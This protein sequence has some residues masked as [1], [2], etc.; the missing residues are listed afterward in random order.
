M[1]ESSTVVDHDYEQ[2][3]GR[4]GEAGTRVVWLRLLWEERR[5]LRNFT[6]CGMG[7]AI[8]V[9]LLLPVSY[10]SRTRLMPPDQQSSSG[11][12]MIAAVAG[13]GSGGDGI[14]G[15]LGSSLGGM[16]GNLLGIKST[17]ALIADML[18][19]PTIQDSLIEK[20]N[21]RKA[22]GA[23]YWEDARRVLASN[24]TIR[25]DKKSGVLTIAVQDRDRNRAQAMAQAYVEALNRLLSQVSTSS[26]RRE[27]LFLEQR[28]QTVK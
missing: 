22:Y 26:A 9:A 7:L 11:L 12:A 16:A 24:T 5:F 8:L 28:L 23:K 21:L 13:K 17:G 3:A 27:R 10:E 2:T 25:E 18:E 14:G 15:S 1:F 6:L 20:L 19:G 4:P